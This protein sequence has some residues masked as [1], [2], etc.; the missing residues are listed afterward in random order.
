MLLQSGRVDCFP[1]IKIPSRIALHD[2]PSPSLGRIA[3]FIR[4]T[5]APYLMHGPVKGGVLVIFGGIFV[6]SMISIQHIEL[7][8]GES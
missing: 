2:A 7:G 5:Y 1:C 3:R 4:R 6:A 8:L